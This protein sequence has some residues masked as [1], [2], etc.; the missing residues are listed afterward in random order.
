MHVWLQNLRDQSR[1]TVDL[2]VSQ[3]AAVPVQGNNRGL[4]Q[5]CLLLNSPDVAETALTSSYRNWVCSS[6]EY[7]RLRPTWITG[8]FCYS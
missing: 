7:S 6:N 1:F 8:G 2:C 4:S 3:D 5:E